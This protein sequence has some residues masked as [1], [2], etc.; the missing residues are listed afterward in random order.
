VMPGDDG[1]GGCGEMLCSWDVARFA[2]ERLEFDPDAT[3]SMRVQSHPDQL[4]PASTKHLSGSTLNA[5]G[6]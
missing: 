6:K 2:C 1:T 3:M 4:E 5:P